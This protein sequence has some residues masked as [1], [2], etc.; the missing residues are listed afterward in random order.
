MKNKEIIPL[1]DEENRSYENQKHCHVCRKLFTKDDKKVRD[2]CH[3]TGK[4]RGA[5][6]SKCNMN[7]KIT[8]NIPIISHS[9]SLYDSHL[10]IKEIAKEFDAELEC[11]GENTKKYISF[12]VKINK[13]IQKKMKIAMKK[14]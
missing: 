4:Y 1:T 9:L 11:L 10:I 8:K 14:L 7:Y 2:H 13:K 12:S 3:F 6:H 5:V